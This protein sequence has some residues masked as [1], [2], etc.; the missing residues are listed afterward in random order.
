MLLMVGLGNPGPRYALTRHN[1]GFMLLDAV[2]NEFS[3][4]WQE[5]H[6]AHTCQLPRSQWQ[7]PDDLLL[8]KPQTFM[9]LS[10]ES[11]QSLMAFYK[12]SPE[13]ILV[14]HDE[15]DIPF[16]E[17]RMQK[18]R[19]HGG[20]NGIR[21][22]HEKIGPDYSRLRLGVGR[23][24]IPQMTVADFVLQPFSED[25][26]SSLPDF[27]SEAAD[28]LFQWAELGFEKAQQTVNQ[29]EK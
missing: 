16:S 9:N 21:N 12:L 8:V 19:G 18:N 26:F 29:Q 15:V 10:G 17:L 6:Q 5:G 23:P 14:A 22:I 11:V 25:E 13:Q 27:L 3:L 28:G 7:G 2:A 20:H 1:I 4:R 24:T